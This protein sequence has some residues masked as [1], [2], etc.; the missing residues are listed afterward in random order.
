MIF[1]NGGSA[2]DAQHIAAEFVGRFA[3]ERLALPAIAL[4]TDTSVLT[5]VAND[6]G[7]EQVFFRQ[8][9]ALATSK[10]VAIAISTSGRSENVLRGVCEPS[11]PPDERDSGR[12]NPVHD[13]E[14]LGG[15]LLIRILQL[16]K[17]INRFD[18]IDVAVR[19]ADPGRSKVAVCTGTTECNIAAPQYS[20]DI[21]QS[22]SSWNRWGVSPGAAVRQCGPSAGSSFPNG[23]VLP[24]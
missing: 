7:F 5:A 19:R 4:T 11:M 20:S 21:Q 12:G 15:A 16:A 24:Q 14:P 2:A 18:F 9:D 3:L 10:D 22:V 1:G 17:L 8:I 23:F 6:Y 13:S